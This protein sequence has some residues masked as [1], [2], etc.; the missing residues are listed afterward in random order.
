[1]KLQKSASAARIWNLKCLSTAHYALLI[2]PEG[3]QDIIAECMENMYGHA[4]QEASGGGYEVKIPLPEIHS[5][6]G[7]LARYTG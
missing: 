4:M 1:M 6:N 3:N 2:L 5:D 7:L